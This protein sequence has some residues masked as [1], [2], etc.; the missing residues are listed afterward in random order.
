MKSIPLIRVGLLL[1][2][3]NFLDHIG[4]PTERLLEQVSISPMALDRPDG[5]LTLYQGASLAE[6]A[7]ALEGIETLGFLI[8]SQT[9][10]PRLG[11]LGK[12]VQNSLTLFDLFI[13]V[14]QVIGMANSGQR[15]SLRWDGDWVWWQFNCENPG[16]ISN[17]QNHRYDLGLYLS[18]LRQALGPNWRPPEL[19]LKEP[20]CQAMVDL[21]DFA[22]TT[23]HFLRPYNA[24]KIPRSALSLPYNPSAPSNNLGSPDYERFQQTAP[25]PAF[26]NSL[27]Q[28]IQAMLPYSYPDIALVAAAS[29]LSVRTLQRILAEAG[30]TYSKLVDRVRFNRAIAL[31]QQPEVKLLDIAGE[32]GYTDPANFTRAFKRWAGISPREYRLLHSHKSIE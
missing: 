28:L 12:L 14:E 21:Q 17:L 23:I 31:L 16:R 6:R 29:G 26:F 5:L 32:L 1:P 24:I 18:A 22:G 7:A 11:T 20:R 19:H 9:P 4:S 2:I 10:P 8:G 30:L 25:D 15:V 27:H 3:V 13:T